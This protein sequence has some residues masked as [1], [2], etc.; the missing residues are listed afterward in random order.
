M[1]EW[2]WHLTQHASLSQWIFGWIFF[3]W[4]YGCDMWLNMSPFHN[5]SMVVTFDSMF[6]F[7][8][9]SM[10][11][12]F[13]SMCLLFTANLW[14]WHVTKKCLPLTVILWL[15]H[16]TQSVSLSQWIY[17]C[18]IW[19][20]VSFWQRIYDCDIWLNMSPFHSKSKVVLSKWI[21]LYKCLVWTLNKGKLLILFLVFNIK[22]HITSIVPEEGWGW[23][24]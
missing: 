14:L 11:V 15:W 7:H 24:A 1:K 2:L 16:L 21:Y 18:G 19:F 12:A 22:I 9:E 13:D 6:P 20:N 10:V 23:A 8:N 5:E 3:Q 4:I 17:S